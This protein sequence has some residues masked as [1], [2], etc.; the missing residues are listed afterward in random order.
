MQLILLSLS[1]LKDFGSV[2][3]MLATFQ[4]LRRT[5]LNHIELQAGSWIDVSA[6]E[7]HSI[8]SR[9]IRRSFRRPTSQAGCLS[10]LNDVVLLV[11]GSI[12]SASFLCHDLSFKNKLL[13]VALDVAAAA[14]ISIPYPSG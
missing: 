14:S 12:R 7:R 11:R 2:A 9:V 6:L 5:K 10:C 1:L 3:T 4:T 13:L 8:D